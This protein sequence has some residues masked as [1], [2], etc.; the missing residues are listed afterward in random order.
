MGA[1]KRVLASPRRWQLLLIC[2]VLGTGTFLVAFGTAPL[3]VQ[4]DAWI[5]AALPEGDTVG[6]YAGWMAFRHSAWAF[7]LTYTDAFCWPDGTL[8]AYLDANPLMCILFK[9]LG[10]LLPE[11]FQF[12]GWFTFGCY[13][14]QGLAAGL[15]L[16]C[17]TDKA[18]QVYPGVLLFCFSPILMERAFRHTQ[19]TAHFLVVLALY[20]YIRMRQQRFR[21]LPWA[22]VGLN[23]LGMSIHPYYIPMVMSLL[24]VAVADYLVAKRAWLRAAGFVAANLAAVLLVGFL[25]GTIGWEN[26]YFSRLGYGYFSMNLNAP[27]NPRAV[28]DYQ[29]SFVLGVHPQQGGQYDGFNYLGLGVLFFLGFVLVHF[30]LRRAQGPGGLVRV[31]WRD[32]RRFVRHR[33]PL[34]VMCLFLT[35]FAVTNVVVLGG[36]TLAVIPLPEILLSLA[37]I[38]RASARMFWPVYYLI[39]AFVLRYFFRHFRGR[40]A[41]VLVW[42]LAAVQLGDM[43]GVV[44]QKHRYLAA[45]PAYTAVVNDAFFEENAAQYTRLVSL[46][47]SYFYYY[48]TSMAAKY[49][50]VTNYGNITSGMSPASLA[51][52]QEAYALLMQGQYSPGT[53]YVAE[54]PEL[55]AE[56]KQHWA[57]DNT[58]IF[59]TYENFTYIFTPL[60]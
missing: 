39:F 38:F 56:L 8:V 13:V 16:S 5:Y 22:F 49:G 53:I 50:L 25:I 19:L 7:P 42:L 35:A 26:A 4:N 58:L 45:P 46:E 60:E 54:T 44:Y 52:G 33:L 31:L 2:A 24:A 36:R 32:G 30:V 12:F 55:V 59:Y 6:H 47:D 17:F 57:E 34:V 9:A 10:P 1:V 43:A 23:A 51:A 11:T 28:G 41:T 20:Y 27:F 15:L 18:W 21:C 48:Y 29:W 3:N 40:A 14:L 37:G